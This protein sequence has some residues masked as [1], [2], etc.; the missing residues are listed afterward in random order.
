M[1]EKA[2]KEDRRVQYTKKVIHETF[3][4]LLEKKPYP[5]I[6]VT[7]LC[8]QADINRGT[9]YTHYYDMEDVLDE[10]LSEILKDTSSVV[11]HVLSVPCGNEGCTYP[12]CEKIRSNDQY[13]ILF[14]DDTVSEKIIEKMSGIKEHF[15][16]WL[17]SHSLLTF[18][19]AEAI[20]HFQMNGCLTI[21]RLMFRNKCTDWRKIQRVVD[22]FIQAGL[23]RFLI[24]DQR[25]EE[26][27]KG[28]K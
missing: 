18:E 14:L 7:E 28:G 21:N 26:L 24:H 10:I 20:F 16:T 2:K 4:K 19:E 25:D 27:Q 17:M 15:I 12:F 6:T 11:E 1:P 5:Q 3:F 13:R 8:R 22:G 23:E 9:F